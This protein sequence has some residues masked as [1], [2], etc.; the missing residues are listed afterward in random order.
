MMKFETKCKN[1]VLSLKNTV[2][3]SS[4]VLNSET[5]HLSLSLLCSHNGFFCC[6]FFPYEAVTVPLI[7]PGICLH[8]VAMCTH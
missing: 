2:P 5:K 7:R 4:V 1:A 6:F 3:Y 8:L